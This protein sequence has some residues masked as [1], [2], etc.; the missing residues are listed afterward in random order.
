MHSGFTRTFLPLLLAF[1]SVCAVPSS[2]HHIDPA[3]NRHDRHSPLE[4]PLVDRY[5]SIWKAARKSVTDVVCDYFYR[6]EGT[7][8]SL[9]HDPLPKPAHQYL[10]LYDNQVVLRFSV[11]TLEESQSLTEAA[12]ILFLDVWNTGSD[13][14]DIRLAT[15]VVR[16]HECR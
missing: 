9:L 16:Q 8:A 3:I 2:T 4:A 10:A 5:P 1:A 11:T 13:G 14:V 6:A 7:Q 12:D 15:D